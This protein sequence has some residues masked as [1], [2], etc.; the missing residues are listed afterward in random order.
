MGGEGVL[1]ISS[2]G[3][4]RMGTK[5]K[6]KKNPWTKNHPPPPNKKKNTIHKGTHT[7]TLTK[8]KDTQKHNTL[9]KSVQKKKCLAI[10]NYEI[11][12]HGD[13]KYWVNNAY[14]TSFPWK[15]FYCT[16]ELANQRA[17]LDRCR[18][19][20]PISAEIKTVDSQSD[21]GILLQFWLIDK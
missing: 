8:I 10:Q 11:E 5:I 4:D 6:I 9:R 14:M 21:L 7:S 2:N 16:R 12:S 15:N 19:T 3:D 18:T 20:R 1:R 13:G 17:A